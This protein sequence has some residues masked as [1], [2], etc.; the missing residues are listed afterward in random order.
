[1][2]SA[3]GAAAAPAGADW[4]RQAVLRRLENGLLWLLVF[5]GAFVLIEPSPYEFMFPLALIVFAATG[6]AV[7]APLMPML[8]LTLLFNGAGTLALIPYFGDEDAV[9]FIAV[10]WYLGITAIFFAALASRETLSRLKVIRSGF[11]AGGVAAALAGIAGYVDIAG[12][13]A[14][15]SLYGRASGTF[16]DPNVLGPFLAVPALF[17]VQGFLVGGL[18]RPLLSALWL[19]IILAGIFLSFSRGAWGVTLAACLLCALL[20]LMTT[21]S[22]KLRAR[23]VLMGLAGAMALTALL[24][25]ALSFDNVQ[26]LFEQR[27]ALQYYDAGA[28]GRFGQLGDMVT[29]VLVKPIGWGPFQVL[30]HFT[31]APHNVYVNAF[32]SYGWLGGTSYLALIGATLVVGWSTVWI[33]SPWQTLFIAVWTV[34]FVQ[35]L[36][37]LQIDTDHWRHFWLLLGLTWG[38]AVASRRYRAAS[39]S[40]PA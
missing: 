26:A 3:Y 8:L 36:Q 17:L 40:A 11:V 7:S 10:S 31:Q 35:I 6:L 38:I 4:R 19:L 29:F 14:Y 20:M 28:Q 1:L 9:L 22:N 27:A 33:K 5:S 16:K 21:P 25:L 23:I 13:S 30:S 12:A 18:R 34:T 15:F 37:G 39:G 2:A 24:I 32:G